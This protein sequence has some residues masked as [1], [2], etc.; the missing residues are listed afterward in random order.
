MF[1]KIQQAGSLF[2]RNRSKPLRASTVE[3]KVRRS[4]RSAFPD[5]IMPLQQ[6]VADEG[7]KE[8]TPIQKQSIPH[9]VNGRDLLGCAQTGTG[10]TAAFTLPILQV[11]AAK[12]EKPESGRPRALILAPTRELAGQV[13]DSIKTYGRH[14]H[15]A[16]TV[17]FGGVGQDPQVKALRQGVDIVVATPGRLLDLINQR[18]LRLDK[19]EILVLDEADRMLDMGFIPDIRKIIK[20]VPDK[21]Q[22][23]FFSATMSKE[24]VALSKTMVKDPVHI[25]IASEAPT[26]E[27]IVQRVMFL[28]R[29]NKRHMLNKLMQD[30]SL[31]KVLIFSNMKHMVDKITQNL[32]DA[33][34]EAIA[35]HG[36]KTQ[37]IRIK[38][39]EDFKSGKVRA[40]VATDIAA[41]GIDIDGISHV[42][43]YD[44]PDEA[45]VYVH[46]IG[47]TAR[48]G[49][50][51]DAISFCSS[52]ERNAL[53]GIE[54]LIEK[55]IPCDKN[56]RFHS[57]A[58]RNATG[59]AAK[60]LPKMPRGAAGTTL[61]SGSFGSIN[62]RRRR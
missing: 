3:A 1:K 27:K 41:R 20:M 21:R 51:G 11:L 56:H 10:K 6:A 61:R 12:K 7:Y 16:S 32:V 34:V 46:R 37:A 48:A 26:V 31:D 55:E 43:N 29:G 58:V 42:I 17:I 23:M 53:R 14:L 9:L 40:L 25:T 5:L 52:E 19:V 2:I 45:E 15:V 28:D 22:S 50:D 35:I 47:R 36:D 49:A 30:E 33:G 62:K 57:E 60:P 44:I 54:R 59:M 13:E 38:A 39:L 24:I 4:A 8:P 18:H